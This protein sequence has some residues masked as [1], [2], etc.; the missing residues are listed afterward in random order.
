MQAEWVH[1]PLHT[2]L[3][4]FHT[5]WISTWESWDIFNVIILIHRLG[6]F[7]QEF[8]LLFLSSLSS[9][10]VH[11]IIHVVWTSIQEKALSSTSKFFSLC[12]RKFFPLALLW[13]ISH[14]CIWAKIFHEASRIYWV[15]MFI[16]FLPLETTFLQQS[17]LE[18]KL[19]TE[20]ALTLCTTLPILH[21]LF[22]L[23]FSGNN[24]GSVK[25]LQIKCKFTVIPL[26][27]KNHNLNK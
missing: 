6:G 7:F 22:L 13:T 19:I 12:M 18:K 1:I 20:T 16:L 23:G 26:M 11:E 21:A 24:W 8:Q 4:M 27:D 15:H 9:Y 2:P 17:S 14:S 10:F 25:K 3:L 5:L